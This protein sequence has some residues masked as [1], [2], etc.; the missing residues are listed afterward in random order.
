MV[1]AVIEGRTLGRSGAAEP[2]DPA[3]VRQRFL[4]LN[5]E[6]L[7]RAQSAMR[8]RHQDF[9]DLLPLL[10]HVNHPILPGFVAKDTPAGVSDY[11]PGRAALL[12]ARRLARTFDYKRRVLPRYDI[13]ALYLMGS[14]GT[15]AYSRKSDFDVWICHRSD[16]PAEGRAALRAKAELI[17]QWAAELDLEVHFFLV[18]PAALRAG[19]HD[20]LSTES[21]GTAQH[22]LLLEEFYRTG[23][24]L[25]GRFPIWWLVPPGQERRY[26]A[27]VR[28]LVERR[29]VAP[30]EFVDFGPV[31]EVPPEEFFG[32]AL[33][34]LYKSI[35]SPYKSALKLKLLELYAARYPRVDLLCQRFKRAVYQGETDLNQL[36]PYLMMYRAIEEHLEETGE[37][38]RLE[39]V[40]RCFYL[41]VHEPLSQPRRRSETDWR[42]ELMQQL[43]ASWGWDR[44]RLELLD[45]R[46]AWKIHQVLRER[47]V[48][49][50][51]LT[52]SYQALSDF[53][54][55]HAELLAIN[56]RDMT[57]LGRKLYAAF[58]RKAGKVEI[59]NR[60][61][62]EDL[63]EGRVSLHQLPGKGREG[64]WAL[65]RG[66]IGAQEQA[67][68]VPLK[69]APQA[70][71]LIAW[72][73]F[74][75]LVNGRTAF[76]LH[77]EGSDLSLR[78][79]LAT[80]KAL[81]R[82][83]PLPETLHA[84][85]QALAAPSRIARA[86]L[87][88]NV[89]LDALRLRSRQGRHLA[90]DRTDALSYSGL[91]ENLALTFDLVLVTSWREVLVWR[92]EGAEGLLRLLREYLRWSPPARGEPPPLPQVHCYTSGR[93][94]SIA[95]RIREL[96]QDV[97]ACFYGPTAH[98]GTR[99]ILA[100]EQTFYGLWM[101]E[102][103]LRFQSLGDCAGL[104]RHLGQGRQGFTPVVL[105][106]YA[107]PDPLLPL[108]YRINR[109]GGVQLV[110]R[111]EGERALVYVVDERGSLFRQ[112]VDFHDRAALL[113]HFHRFFTAVGRRQRYEAL[114]EGAEAAP[115]VEYYEAVRDPAGHLR[116]VRQEPP[117]EG[118]PYVNIQVVAAE[119]EG[120]HL[121]IY[122]DD[123]EFSTLEHGGRLF[124]RVAA[125]VLRHR[126]GGQ[127]YPI[128]VTDVD[129]PRS[130]LGAQP[131]MVQTVHFLKQKRR[132]EQ[133]LN[134]ALA[135]LEHPAG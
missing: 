17:E 43:T 122:C 37:R 135:R 52:D 48:L 72:S 85:L 65:Y 56:E 32:A 101:E 63:W 104:L 24:L 15:V 64:G 118:G 55:R 120:S 53:A 29:F 110:Y 96:F 113:S 88:I 131:G 117:R 10:L 34:Q 89:G 127:R 60:G 79:L 95:R 78:E 111:V 108:V 44:A 73:Y 8:E 39:F 5:R 132:T 57:L 84:D 81:E 61:I 40:R 107:Q 87:F 94:E 130:L 66:T 14:G 28:E 74:N 18:D 22:Y 62:S 51:E 19:R 71:E 97:A 42:R 59:V 4:L 76:A 133:L 31:V 69:R 25:A 99:Y 45:A 16:L 2:A 119:G 47:R 129:L 77:T 30:N 27:C 23:L 100:V 105:D 58:E 50:R 12:A 54:R 128:Y 20:D 93:G 90:T 80:V 49:V 26:E 115:P 92:Y 1:E 134:E 68:S 103:L 67:Y 109:P 114:L 13:H 9:L 86:S 106:R 112:R 46:P 38:E 35:D 11:R 126:R 6:R 70:L 83:F 98:P 121:T 41:K 33:W 36:D 75:G 3:R 123:E 125:H 124:E 21:S 82:D 7:R 116:L 91:G 102:G